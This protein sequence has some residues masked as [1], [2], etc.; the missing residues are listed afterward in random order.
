MSPA[1]R[2]PSKRDPWLVAVLALSALSCVFAVPAAGAGGSGVTM[3]ALLPV[4]LLGAGLPLWV[5]FATHYRFEADTLCVRCGPFS[6]R[7]PLNEVRA[8]TS[9]RSALSGPALSP[10]RLRIDYGRGRTLLV[11]PADRAGFL[12]ELRLRAPGASI[13]LSTVRP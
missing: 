8:V 6:W 9:S 12:A 5:L 1:P 11:S 13:T 4:L 3:L 7:V 10:D 2:F